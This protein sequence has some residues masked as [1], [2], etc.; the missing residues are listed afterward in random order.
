M[1]ILLTIVIIVLQFVVGH[2][3]G[4]GLA[5]AT[6]AGNG[7]ELVIMPLGQTVGVWG[8]GTLAAALRGGIT[9]RS[10][11][12]TFAGAAVGSAIGVMIIRV[13]P[14]IGFI[15]ILYPLLGALTGFYASRSVIA[16]QSSTG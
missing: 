8:I 9:A 7:W 16:R 5:I 4:F 3:L 10:A 14:A 6:G 11:A 2:I 1:N 15:Q 12:L 13:T